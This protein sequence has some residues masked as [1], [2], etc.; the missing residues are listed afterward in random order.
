MSATVAIA[1]SRLDRLHGRNLKI[2]TYDSKM[3]F[4][5]FEASGRKFFGTVRAGA[6]G[7]S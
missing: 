7:R 3:T 4:E 5:R 2:R 1:K 6:A